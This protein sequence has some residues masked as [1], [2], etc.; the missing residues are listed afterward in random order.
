MVGSINQSLQGT[1][2][3]GQEFS[4][5]IYLIYNERIHSHSKVAAQSNTSVTPISNK[6]MILSSLG[7]RTAQFN[8]FVNE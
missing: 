2:Q 4:F 3:S 7:G 1:K 8:I 5:Y 6:A